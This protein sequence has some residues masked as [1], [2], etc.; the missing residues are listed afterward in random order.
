MF[1]EP[2]EVFFN[3]ADFATPA[4]LNGSSVQ[5]IFD[6]A[7]AEAFSVDG[8]HPSALLRSADV[9]GVV[10]GATLIVDAITYRIAGVQ[11]DGQG[12]TRL[13]LEKN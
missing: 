3:A 10:R 8:V 1:A 12:T 6:A 5:V 2:L 9:V 7:Y 13:I 11:P 4:T